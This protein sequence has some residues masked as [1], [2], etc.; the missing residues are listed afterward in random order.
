[1]LLDSTLVE[2]SKKDTL[3]FAATV[4]VSITDWWFLKDKARLKYLGLE[5]ATIKLQR[6]DS[7]WNYQFLVD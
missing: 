4:K 1:M 6:T 3:L 2:D 7:V 5:N